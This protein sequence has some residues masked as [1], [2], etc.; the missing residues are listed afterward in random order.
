MQGVKPYKQRECEWNSLKKV[1][2]TCGIVW[3]VS[4][5]DWWLVKKTS[6][7]PKNIK[8]EDLRSI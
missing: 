3:N 7:N 6:L 1:W 5:S 8:S 4:N 2:K